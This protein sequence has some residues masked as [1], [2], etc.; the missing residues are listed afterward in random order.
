M[1]ISRFID[2]IGNLWTEA[3]EAYSL[4][5]MQTLL[6]LVALALLG[7]GGDKMRLEPIPRNRTLIMDCAESNTC[8]GQIQDY[9]A[10]N[11]YLPGSTSRTGYNFL[12]SL[13]PTWTKP[14]GCRIC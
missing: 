14:S 10:F 3:R 6:T 5:I 7:C 4:A 12:S 8:A 13:C 9:N 2:I 1:S 11:P